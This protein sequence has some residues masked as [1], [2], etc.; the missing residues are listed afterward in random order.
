VH[1]DELDVAFLA[2]QICL[3]IKPL[4]PVLIRLLT[5]FGGSVV[6]YLIRIVFRH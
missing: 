4:K 1:F 3:L 2:D 6:V 5:A